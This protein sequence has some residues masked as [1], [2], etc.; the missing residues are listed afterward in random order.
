MTD[1]YCPECR[2]KWPGTFNLD[3]RCTQCGSPIKAREPWAGM[4]A[5]IG[6]CMKQPNS[7]AKPRRKTMADYR[8]D[9]DGYISRNGAPM[10]TDEIIGALKNHDALAAH[11]EAL[12]AWAD[13]YIGTT[14]LYEEVESARNANTSS[15]ARLKAKWQA[16]ALER[17]DSR[18]PV[19]QASSRI[20]VRK[21]AREL[22]RQAQGE[23]T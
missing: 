23:L 8:V 22:R 20:I 6:R 18:M 19:T 7:A 17:A 16:E 11:V 4:P 12:V 5:L 13:A 1:Y 9:L 2:D 15:L 3:H 21:M 14:G 10:T